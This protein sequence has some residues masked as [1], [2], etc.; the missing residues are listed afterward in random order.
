M[1]W[2]KLLFFDEQIFGSHIT[3]KLFKKE[4]IKEA[5]FTNDCNNMDSSISDFVSSISRMVI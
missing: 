2:L 4:E 1:K 5:G 3:L